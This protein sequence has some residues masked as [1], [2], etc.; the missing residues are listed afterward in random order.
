MDQ[1][2]LHRLAEGGGLCHTCGGVHTPKVDQAI[3]A[4]AAGLPAC[5]C[6]CSICA[7]FNTAVKDI[8]EPVTDME[9]Y[10]GEENDQ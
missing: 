6:S 8:M 10:S 9:D 2:Q 7:K 5:N 3:L 1:K 4:A